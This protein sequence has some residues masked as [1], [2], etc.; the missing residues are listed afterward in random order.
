M[1]RTY[2]F[3]NAP[4]CS[5]TSKRTCERSKAPVVRGWTVCRF[6]GARG[7]GPRGK[8]NGMFKHGLYTKEAVQEH[9]LFRNFFDNRAEWE[10][11]GFR[12]EFRRSSGAPRSGPKSTSSGSYGNWRRSPFPISARR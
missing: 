8:R 11:K 3:L 1:N 5:A 2:A 9:R 6:H 7:D 10:M 4:C 12:R